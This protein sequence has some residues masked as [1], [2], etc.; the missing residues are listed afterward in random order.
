MAALVLAA[1]TIKHVRTGVTHP[2]L[3]LL[4]MEVFDREENAPFFWG[5]IA[6]NLVLGLAVVSLLLFILK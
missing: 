2:M 1:T 6:F 4:A 5:I 3:D